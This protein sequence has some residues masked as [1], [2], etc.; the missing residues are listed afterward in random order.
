MK[1]KS[2]LGVLVRLARI[3]ETERM[4][5][6]GV[7]RRELEAVDE[8]IAATRAS[9]AQAG[10]GSWLLQHPVVSVQ[11]LRGATR[12]ALHVKEQLALLE[13]TRSGVLERVERARQALASARLRTRAL[14]DVEQRRLQRALRELHKRDAR[15]AEELERGRTEAIRAHR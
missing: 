14:E 3:E 1:R 7:V 11:E 8:R 9:A 4:R 6:F 13:H 12:H 2:R 10:A 5:A 15:R